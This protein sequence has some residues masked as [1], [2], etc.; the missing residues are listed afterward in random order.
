ML[1]QNNNS[2]VIKGT[3][4]IKAL[5]NL[6]LSA[7]NG[8]KEAFGQVYVNLYTPLYRYVISRCHDPNLAEDVCQQTFLKFYGALPNYEPLTSPLAYLF[9]VAKR[10]LINHKEK[11][12]PVFFDESIL[13]SLEDNSSDVVEEL[14]VKI[15][16][17]KIN[18]Y[19]PYLT[20]DEQDVTRLYFYS[21]YEYKEIAEI[22]SKE[23]AS[24]RKI[25]ER[26]L[27]KLRA[28]TNHIKND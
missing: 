27:K 2:P 1:S 10:I 24:I 17:E 12:S 11:E 14:D 3:G 22:L 21:E 16:A 26:A 15:L 19:L 8:N 7:K 5:Q 25:K 28:L 20:E 23:E 13:E 9:T 4:D 6:I 18:T